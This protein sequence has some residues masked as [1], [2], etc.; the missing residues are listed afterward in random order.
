[1]QAHKNVPLV[2]GPAS[3]AAASSTPADKP[4]AAAAP[5]AASSSTP[6]APA[7]SPAVDSKTPH[8]VQY[9]I[10]SGVFNACE[11][12]YLAIK[13]KTLP[14]PKQYKSMAIEADGKALI[15]A[16]SAAVA[17]AEPLLKEAGAH[18]TL[19]RE[20]QAL[21]ASLRSDFEK[22]IA[23]DVAYMKIRLEP[24]AARPFVIKPAA[25]KKS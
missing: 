10:V 23:A 24:A 9:R 17:D 19:T 2:Q 14:G 25:A 4:T 12:L 22:L 11:K 16:H 15:E 18:P 7:A 13:Q 8:S 1:M 6:T 21:C 5:A 20:V 3:V